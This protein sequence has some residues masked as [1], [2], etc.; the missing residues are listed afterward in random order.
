LANIFY[1]LPASSPFAGVFHVLDCLTLIFYLLF[2]WCWL[3]AASMN[4]GRVRDTL[5]SQGVLDRVLAGDV[6]AC[7]QQLPLCTSCNLPCPSGAG[8]CVE[9]GHCVL[10]LDH[11]CEVAGNCIGDRN[12]K[13]FILSFF[14]SFLFGVA[15]SL[16][17]FARF[18]A[19]VNKATS[20][21]IM[22]SAIYSLVLGVVLCAFACCSISCAKDTIVKKSGEGK[23]ASTRFWRAFGKHWWQRIVPI[24]RTTTP[25]AWP[26]VNWADVV[27]FA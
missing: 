10:R 23:D 7:L 11:H 9:C 5:K 16:V 3:S 19:N 6:P 22:V 26:G 20:I 2:V 17:G 21:L 15:N 24:Q 13:A 14:Y 12:F 18:A 4:P 8:H 27:G 1:S 25:L